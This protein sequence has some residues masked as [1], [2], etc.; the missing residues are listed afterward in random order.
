M[1]GYELGPYD[2]VSHAD[3][4]PIE[5]V[6]VLGNPMPPIPETVESLAL[7]L[8]SMPTDEEGVVIGDMNM[9]NPDS[10]ESEEQMIE[11]TPEVPIWDDTQKREAS[12]HLEACHPI[13][14]TLGPIPTEADIPAIADHTGDHTLGAMD[15]LA[16]LEPNQHQLAHYVQQDN[17]YPIAGG[18][19]IASE[20]G[21]NTVFKIVAAALL[22][23]F[24]RPGYEWSHV[25]YA[26][27]WFIRA[28]IM[29]TAMTCGILSSQDFKHLGMKLI[30]PC[31]DS[32]VHLPGVTHPEYFLE[33]LHEVAGQFKG[34]LQ[35]KDEKIGTEPEEDMFTTWA[36]L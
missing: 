30:N 12:K 5:Q 10:P 9:S 16:N 14:S 1:S 19:D 24:G 2:T 28:I 18:L 23:G 4:S 29:T 25:L 7:P 3:P 13:A 34:E 22:T 11:D 6:P 26:K 15:A 20:E 33:L 27:N 21:I 31:P 17:I 8:P 35:F 32:L 36:T